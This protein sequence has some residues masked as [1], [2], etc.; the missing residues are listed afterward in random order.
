VQLTWLANYEK[1]EKEIPSSDLVRTFDNALKPAIAATI[2]LE[3][4][5]NG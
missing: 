4:M 2:L 5:S 1:A 3:S